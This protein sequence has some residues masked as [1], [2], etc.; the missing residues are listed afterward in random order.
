MAELLRAT[1]LPWFL[2]Y[3]VHE[4]VMTDLYG[5]L[6]TAELDIAHTTQRHRVGA[7]YAVFSDPLTV[8]GI[9]LMKSGDSRWVA[10]QGPA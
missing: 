7:E 6:R 10:S 9:G 8:P 2:T 3:D 1:G 4:Q 5:G